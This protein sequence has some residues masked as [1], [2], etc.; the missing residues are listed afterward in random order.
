MDVATRGN[1]GSDG[2]REVLG[3]GRRERHPGRMAEIIANEM[4]AS[5][6][7]NTSHLAAQKKRHTKDKTRPQSCIIPTGNSFDQ[8]T[9]EE[10]SDADDGNYEGT[11]SSVSSSSN[12]V[13][14][15]TN[16]EVS[17]LLPVYGHH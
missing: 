7:D 1:T 2:F 9:I 15:I 12:D 16:E 3:R 5:D 4:L 11:A 14:E 8:L 6:E 13:E 17:S 10:S